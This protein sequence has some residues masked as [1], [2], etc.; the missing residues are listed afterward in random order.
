MASDASKVRVGVTGAVHVGDTD[1]TLPTDATTAVTGLGDVGYISEDGITETHDDETE[2]IRAWQNG[3]EV[4]RVR[5][6]HDV[7]WSFTFIETSATTMREFYGNHN[8]GTTEITGEALPHRSWVF[9]VIDGDH[10]LRVVI[11][12]GQVTERGDITYAGSDPVGREV[13]VTAFPDSDGVKATI[14][15]AEIDPEVI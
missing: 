15:M 4:R 9:D 1:A 10:V 13:T 8:D 12:D 14:Y 2:S 3:D 5:T 7:S 6:S 11:P